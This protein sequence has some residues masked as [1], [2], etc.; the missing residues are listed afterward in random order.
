MV[1]Q[2]Q[3]VVFSQQVS[4]DIVEFVK[5]V[6]FERHDERHDERRDEV[7]HPTL[8]QSEREPNTE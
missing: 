3:S 5:H 6:A 2:S 1:Y 8:S 4:G 7:P